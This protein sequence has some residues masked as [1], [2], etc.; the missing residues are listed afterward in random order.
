M[1]VAGLWQYP[2]KSMQ[3]V[4]LPSAELTP[5]GLAG[6]RTWAV[7]DEV[8]GGVGGGKK[9]PGLMRLAAR[10]AGPGVAI[11]LPDGSIVHSDDAD[12]DRRLSDAVG[13]PVTLRRA[14]AD[15]E[16][17]RRGRP[18]HGDLADELRDVFGRVDDEPLPD[19][20][21]LVRELAEQGPLH[22]R[23]VD[24]FPVH[25]ITT[26]ALRAVADAV[27]S[28]AVDVRRFR[29]NVVVDSGD[30]PGHPELG[31]VGGTLHIGAAEL[32][33]VVGCPRCV[34]VTHAVAPDVPQDRAILRH[35]VR[36]LGQDVG[37]YAAVP[38]S[39]TIRVGDAVTW[40]KARPD[41]A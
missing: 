37:V 12:V 2:V 38:A 5:T 19:L 25:V 11:T 13:H 14:R 21:D 1:R 7:W 36:D 40:T 16:R 30:E 29:P 33:V 35:V 22:D 15:D 39:A 6:D 32:R 10:H 34:M 23:Y 9:I 26:S 24:A 18:D 8:R 20:S 4:E 28:S 17:D 3:G 27:P 41:G 31:W